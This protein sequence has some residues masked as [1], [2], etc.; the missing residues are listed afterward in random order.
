MPQNWVARVVEEEKRKDETHRRE[1]AAAVHHADVIRFHLQCFMVALKD[2]VA[3]DVEAF[4]RELPDRRVSFEMC[5]FDDGF[6]VRRDCYPEVHLTV[7]PNPD[8]GSIRVQY[9]F[10]SADGLSAPKLVELAPDG[11]R[12]FAVHVK[13]GERQSFRSVEELSEHLL[14]PLFTGHS[15]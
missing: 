7:T 15:R 1:V 3:R 9:L 13:D 12:G 6:S 2:R 11:E 10:A 4:A 5:G 8:D 14:V